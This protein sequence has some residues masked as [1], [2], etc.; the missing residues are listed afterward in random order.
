MSDSVTIFTSD[1]VIAKR[2]QEQADRIA[3]LEA[4]LIE[5]ERD[6]EQERRNFRELQA[7]LDSV[8]KHSYHH[9]DCN[10]WKWD[11]VYS[12]CETGRNCEKTGCQNKRQ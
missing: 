11:W 1:M 10:C 9:P 7:K 6:W 3:E 2:L 5:A 8:P 4:A 12:W